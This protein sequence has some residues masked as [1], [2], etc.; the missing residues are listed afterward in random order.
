MERQLLLDDVEER[1]LHEVPRDLPE[2]EAILL[3]QVAVSREES[4]GL[5]GLVGERHRALDDGRMLGEGKVDQH[6]TAGCLKHAGGGNSVAVVDAR[7]DLRIA[8]DHRSAQTLGRTEVRQLRLPDLA[9]YPV[10][11]HR[12]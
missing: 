8:R 12:R 7:R 10:Y 1:F 4:G 2:D 3:D 5:T 9:V 11:D 6:V